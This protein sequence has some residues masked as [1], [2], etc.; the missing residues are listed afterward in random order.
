[1]ASPTPYSLSYDFT[2]FQGSNLTSPLPADKFETEFN[3]I[4]TTTGEIIANLGLIQRSDGALAN[5]VV[6]T[7]SLDD[8]MLALLGDT[9]SAYNTTVE[10]AA[11]AAASASA[12]ASSASAAST[13]ESNASTSETNAAA[14]ASAAASSASAAAASAASIDLTQTKT[15]AEDVDAMEVCYINGSG[16]L[17][18]ADASAEATAKGA[19]RLADE[20][21]L[22]GNSGTFLLPNAVK[23]TSG[24]TAGAVYYL[25]ETAG[26]ITTTAPTTSGAIVRVVGYAESTTDFYFYPDATFI[27][28]P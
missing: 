20:N 6:T 26:A 18:L 17:N 13:S 14:S 19:L 23:V 16:T 24:L 12:A 4:S 11:A 1:M 25:S 5:G 27:E 3:N 7:D 8:T 28:V 22:N 2:G 10:N 15:V 21:I 9:I